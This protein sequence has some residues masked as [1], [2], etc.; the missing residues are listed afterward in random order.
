MESLLQLDR[1]RPRFEVGRRDKPERNQMVSTIVF[2]MTAVGVD[3]PLPENDMVS[4]G[5]WSE[6]VTFF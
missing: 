3:S 6:Y 4:S 5:P 1:V 2:F